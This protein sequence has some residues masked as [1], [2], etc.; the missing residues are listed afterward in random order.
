M[1]CCCGLLCWGECCWR[2]WGAAGWPAPAASRCSLKP[3]SEG[4]LVIGQRCEGS[5]DERRGKRALTHLDGR[6]VVLEQSAGRAT[7]QSAGGASAYL[8]RCLHVCIVCSHVGVQGRQPVRHQGERT[9]RRGR[10]GSRCFAPDT[11][12]GI[13]LIMEQ[14]LAATRVRRLAE[15]SGVSDSARR[16]RRGN[17]AWSISFAAHCLCV[18]QCSAAQRREAATARASE[19]QQA[20]AACGWRA[21]ARERWCWARWRERAGAATH[22]GAG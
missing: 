5:V 20:A 12:S 11:V 6:L 15:W 8:S 1:A 10:V 22:P 13:G 9:E 14:Q 2:G 4:V 16:R 17:L 18:C 21:R 7:E 3:A 19:Q